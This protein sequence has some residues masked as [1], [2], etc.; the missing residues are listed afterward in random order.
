MSAAFY[1][2]YQSE[3]VFFFLLGSVPLCYMCPVYVDCLMYTQKTDT[4]R[5]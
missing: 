5:S 2:C 1:K 3:K 4:N